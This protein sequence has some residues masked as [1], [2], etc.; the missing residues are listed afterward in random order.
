M[1]LDLFQ[2]LAAAA[3]IFVIYIIWVQNSYENFQDKNEIYR[4]VIPKDLPPKEAA[5]SLFKN[6]NLEIKNYLNPTVDAIKRL[7]ALRP[8]MPFD[9]TLINIQ[10][11]LREIS[12]TKDEAI[13]KLMKMADALP[14][15]VDIYKTTYNHLI[16]AASKQY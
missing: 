4:N 11:S 13:V 3:V 1:R 6:I 2:T 7:T 10:K 16:N 9:N 12:A 15:N 8:Q 14:S 5:A